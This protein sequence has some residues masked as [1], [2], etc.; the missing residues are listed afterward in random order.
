MVW[1]FATPSTELPSGLWAGIGPLQVGIVHACYVFLFVLVWSVQ[2]KNSAGIEMFFF[3]FVFYESL[4]FI[5]NMCKNVLSKTNFFFIRATPLKM[6]FFL[7]K[8]IVSTFFVQKYSL[9]QNVIVLCVEMAE[10]FGEK[11]ENPIF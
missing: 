3:V 10:I 6:W 5:W 1:E 2:E 8:K 9:C 7:G 11:H 4:I